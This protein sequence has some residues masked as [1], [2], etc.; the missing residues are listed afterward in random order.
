MRAESGPP[1]PDPSVTVPWTVDTEPAASTAECPAQPARTMASR[2]TTRNHVRS[3]VVMTTTSRI[4]NHQARVPR[5]ISVAFCRR[6]PPPH[7]YCNFVA[8]ALVPAAQ[9]CPLASQYIARST[10]ICAGVG[11]EALD[12]RPEAAADGRRELRA[13]LHVETAVAAARRTPR[14]ALVPSSNSNV[15]CTSRRPQTCWRRGCTSPCRA[16]HP[17]RPRPAPTASPCVVAPGELCALY[18][19]AAA[20]R[21]PQRALDDDRHAVGRTD[22]RRHRGVGQPRVFVVDPDV[23]AAVG[24]DRV[25]L[26]DRRPVGQQVRRLDLRG[27]RSRD[28]RPARTGRSRAP[29]RLRPGTT[30]SAGAVTPALSCPAPKI[31][32]GTSRYSARSTMIGWSLR[33]SITGDTSVAASAGPSPANSR[34]S[35]RCWCASPAAARRSSRAAR[36][37]AAGTR[38]RTCAVVG[39]RVLQQVE[40]VEAAVRRPLGEVPR[41]AGAAT[42]VSA[43]AP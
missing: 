18:H 27:R 29:S 11:A 39:V 32:P 5:R 23:E 36:R 38:T 34:G 14:T 17:P 43:C 26:H 10:T 42:A 3:S 31:C 24:G 8:S 7:R 2:L 22:G 15:T 28:S 12:D 4:D 33:T 16:R 9:C 20:P 25:R 40:Q 37:S 41:R 6:P 35:P 30:P 1:R 19:V 21:P 13:H